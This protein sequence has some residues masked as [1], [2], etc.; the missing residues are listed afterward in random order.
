MSSEELKPSYKLRGTEVF[1]DGGMAEEKI[2]AI[3]LNNTV[4]W[5]NPAF[6]GTLPFDLRVGESTRLALFF[7][8]TNDREPDFDLGVRRGHYRSGDVGKVFFNSN[9]GKT[10]RDLDL[11]GC[12][13]LQKPPNPLE[14]EQWRQQRRSTYDYLGLLDKYD[15]MHD[16][17]ISELLNK[18]GVRTH[19]SIA[20]F[21]LH[22][23]PV[24]GR[25]T[26]T[27]YKLEKN[28]L[29]R[30]G[31]E[32][33]IQMRAF[34]TKTRLGEIG[35]QITMSNE[36]AAVKIHDALKL[37]SAEMKQGPLTIEEYLE[38]FARTLGQNVGLMHKLGYCHEYLNELNITLDCRIVDFDSVRNVSTIK[39]EEAFL[40]LQHDKNLASTA[41]ETYKNVLDNLIPSEDSYR[42]TLG[43]LKA[44]DRSYLESLHS[45]PV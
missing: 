40:L 43:L 24:Y 4:E 28:D 15:A 42:S 32:P 38:W 12:G 29:L 22:E 27:I 41:L 19:R 36:N 35:D 13:L 26:E 34:G 2:P 7:D 3:E 30:E 17:T 14:P 20:V 1:P 31:I 25:G 6:E 33:V 45:K 44:Y 23:L 8:A 9:D 10:Y 5:V 18:E 37:L 11:K 39:Q 16:S 21:R